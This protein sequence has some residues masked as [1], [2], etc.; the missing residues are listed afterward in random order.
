MCRTCFVCLFICLKF[1]YLF[2]FVCLFVVYLDLDSTDSVR[3]ICV[4]IIHLFTCLFT[5]LF[6]FVCL[7]VY[8]PAAAMC[9]FCTNRLCFKM[10]N[11]V[12]VCLFVSLFV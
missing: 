1:V 7:F 5:R 10:K 8:S 3:T 11:V 6:L 12:K 9:L 2:V 4:T